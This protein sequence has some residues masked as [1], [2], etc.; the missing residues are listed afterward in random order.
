[1]LRVLIFWMA[2]CLVVAA[3]ERTFDF[4]QTKVNETPPGFRS[5]VSGEGQPGE[6]KV[7]LDEGPSALPALSPKAPAAAKQP[8]LAQLSREATDEHFPLLVFDEETYSDFTF[9][10]R[11]KTVSGEAEQMAGLA[12]RIQD[13]KNY[14]VVRLSSLGNNVRFYKFVGGLRSPPIGPELPVPKGVWHELAVECRGNQ[15]RV[16]FNG[17]EAFPPLSDNSFSSGKVGFWTKSDSVSHFADTRITYTPKER[18][19]D[20]V[21][22]DT[23]KRFG[24]VRGLKLFAFPPGKDQP[25]VIAS[26]AP[27]DLGQTGGEA[28]TKCLKDGTPFIGKSRETVAVMLPVRDRN[29]E[30]VA[31]ARVTLDTFMGQTENNALIRT[32]PIVKF[33]ESRVIA[34]SEALR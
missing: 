27:G 25:E 4:S 20:V 28:E 1:M 5:L 26:K 33:I 10:A 14:Y 7:V 23:L 3:D 13:E 18:T 32:R 31:A 9:R 19:M 24:K 22:A 17:K 21:I 30:I 34:A 16:S 29:G 11:V 15:I 8:V 6:W 12:F 2:A